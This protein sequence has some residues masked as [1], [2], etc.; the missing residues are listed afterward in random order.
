L[1]RGLTQ[2]LFSKVNNL[3]GRLIYWANREGTHHMRLTG[4][5]FTATSS[6]SI[7]KMSLQLLTN[8][9]AAALLWSFF[10]SFSFR[11]NQWGS[12]QKN[13]TFMSLHTV[14]LKT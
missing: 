6:V 5:I 14:I 9:A 13:C 11:F 10:R 1:F 7:C 8:Q 3:M 4:E 12:V 2:A